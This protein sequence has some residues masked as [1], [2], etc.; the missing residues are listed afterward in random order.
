MLPKDYPH[1]PHGNQDLAVHLDG[2]ADDDRAILIPGKVLCPNLLLG[3]KDRDS[4]ACSWI[5]ELDTVALCEVT[6]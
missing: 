3:V 2:F 4:I 1:L 6:R 5:D